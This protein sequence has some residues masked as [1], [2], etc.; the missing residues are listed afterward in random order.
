MKNISQTTEKN[1]KNFISEKLNKKYFAKISE[2]KRLILIKI[3]TNFKLL[4]KK[5]YINLFE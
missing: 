4:S 1:T 5:L 2:I 3:M